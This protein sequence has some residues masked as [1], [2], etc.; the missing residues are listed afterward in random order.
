MTD[1]HR[2]HT[3][4]VLIV[5]LAILALPAPG[6]AMELLVPA[7]CYPTIG[8]FWSTL[9]STAAVVPLTAILDPASGPGAQVDPNYVAAVGALRSAGGRVIGYVTSSYATR[10][11]GDVEA[12]VETYASFYAI[13][14]IFVDEMTSDSSAAH[15]GFYAGLYD[16]IKSHH[17]GWTV[18][19][20]PGT[21]TR[22]AYL[23]TPTVDALVTFEHYAGYPSYVPDP[24][25]GG[26]APRCFAHLPYRVADPDTMRA[27]V[28]LAAE[29]NAGLIFVTDDDLPNPYDQLPAWWWDEVAAV[30]AVSAAGTSPGPGAGPGTGRPDAAPALS[31]W[32]SPFR[33]GGALSV[34]VASEEPVDVRV[35]DVRGRVVATLARGQV[36]GPAL[37]SWR[38]RD[39]D[40]RPVPGG[41][42]FVVARGRADA[43]S[44]KLVLVR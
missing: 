4:K 27:Y 43:A 36:A 37:L 26:Y 6:R 18:I 11:L 38:G 1:S 2:R 22:E 21:N 30:Q 9:N 14:G 5:L 32:P 17:P 31:A 12:E 15:L 44:R 3:G 24:W 39:D 40:A 19:G 28:W 8:T 34:Q 7:Y 23:A 13:D 33:A 20:N 16:W 10:N 29:R 42:Y 41:V 35:L 25:V